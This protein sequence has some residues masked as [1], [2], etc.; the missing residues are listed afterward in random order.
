MKA[1]LKE[2][3]KNNPVLLKYLRMLKS[4]RKLRQFIAV[5]TIKG[6][7]NSLQIEKSALLK[8][9]KFDIQGDNNCIEI[10][11]SCFLNGLTFYIRGNSNKVVLGKGVR[12]NNSGH[13]WVE[14]N[15]CVATIGDNTTIEDA[16]LAVTESNSKIEIG[17]DCMFA[18][19]IDLRTG[20][21][22]S[23]IDKTTRERI[24]PAQ[25]ISI[26]NHV[27]V[28]SHVSIL[29]GVQI[30]DNSVVASRAVVTKSF[31][32]SNILM[33]GMPARILKEN[34]D[35]KRERIK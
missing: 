7:N 5:K 14:D 20:D 17:R 19:D 29:K 13:I 25:N 18:Y 28:A 26:G 1:H 33:G 11:A 10:H 21:S 9:C 24:N 2:L 30:A 22:H 35:W 8:N 27:W 34:I 31:S 15:H 3:V 32:E 6:K 12:F 16:H 23:I 4:W